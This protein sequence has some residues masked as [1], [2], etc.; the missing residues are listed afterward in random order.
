MLFTNFRLLA[1]ESKLLENSPYDL[2][3]R[4]GIFG[5]QVIEYAIQISF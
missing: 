4:S 2:F 3:S 5:R 1:K